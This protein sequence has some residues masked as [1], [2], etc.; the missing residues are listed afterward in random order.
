M[1]RHKGIKDVIREART[2][3]EFHQSMIHQDVEKSGRAQEEA[4]RKGGFTEV[5]YPAAI[6][7]ANSGDRSF[8]LL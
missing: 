1:T 5:V 2:S 7:P 8:G 3:P 6:D 4:I